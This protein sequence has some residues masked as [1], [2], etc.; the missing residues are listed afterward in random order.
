MKPVQC[1]VLEVELPFRLKF[2]HSLHERST[3]SS[4]LVRMTSDTG[5]VGWGES[6]P[7]EYVTGE[8]T[9]SVVERI[10]DCFWPLL[11]ETRVSSWEDGLEIA[12]NLET[13]AREKHPDLPHRI[14][15]ARCA[16][17]IAFLDLIGNH[18]RRSI[19]EIFGRRKREWVEYSGVVS[20][21]SLWKVTKTSLKMRIGGLRF[22][23][24]K[25]GSVDDKDRLKRIR[26]LMGSE[27]D[28]RVDAN[29]AWNVTEAI[30]AIQSIKPFNIS[31]IEQPIPADDYEGLQAITNA[32]TTPIMV[33][34]SLCSMEDARKLVGMD[35]CDYFN[36]R[37]SK[38]GGLFGA[39]E[40]AE[41]ARHQDKGCQLGCQ[42]GETAILSAAGRHFA[43]GV[44]GLKFIEGSFGTHLLEQDVSK[45]DL[46]FRRK[47]IGKPLS[48]PGLGVTVIPERIE[49]HITCRHKLGEET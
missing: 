45:E 33:D 21:D 34:E 30:A 25:V 14:G 28:I 10:R 6:L 29:A 22:I 42:V 43:M 16:I 18:F 11:H 35:A 8:T 23:K 24:V 32:V 37:L 5:E 47:G 38:C 1:E 9:Q 4:V 17:E 7:R 40:M 12:K 27:A 13:A 20:G 15:A 46:T 49:P 41:F 36:I 2:K 26:L 31:S 3:S 39:L 19:G 48:G 44:A